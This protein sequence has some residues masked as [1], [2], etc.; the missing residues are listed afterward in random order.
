[1]QDNLNMNSEDIISEGERKLVINAFSIEN[2]ESVRKISV[3]L[4]EY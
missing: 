1:M 4:N 2:Y 3:I